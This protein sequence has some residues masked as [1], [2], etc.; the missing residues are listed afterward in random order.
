MSTVSPIQAFR[1]SN[2][3]DDSVMPF[4]VRG[5]GIRGRLVRLGDTVADIV[6]RH[7]YPRSVSMLLAEAVALT[8]MLGSSL[9]FEGKLIL[10]ARG[11]GPV[12]ILVV[13]FATPGL[14]RGYAHFDRGRVMAL[15]REAGADTGSLLGDG[16]LAMTIDQGAH[17]ERY[18]GIV[19]LNGLSLTEASNTYFR[20]SE[21]L[22]S[23]V[24]LAAGPIQ[25]FGTR[26]SESWRAGGILIQH[27][28]DEGEPSPI[29]MS[30]GDAPTGEEM[31]LNE[32][33]RWVRGRLLLATV[34]DHELLDPLL[35]PERLLYRLFHEDGVIAYQPAGIS[36]YCQCSQEKVADLLG[37]FSE[38]ELADM[39]EDGQVEV[40]CEFCSE[41]YTFERSELFRTH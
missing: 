36:R 40:T 1:E 16:H 41:R 19:P 9:K 30:S 34:E 20:Q 37:R 3:H 35:A 11:D 24:R 27:L 10:Q 2:L 39:I 15:E 5:L 23:D 32:D 7:D 26:G 38:A 12:D 31:P 17:M 22:P 8:A 4:E 29:A 18:Q 14:M 6:A 33:D 28:P 25:R 21:Q 13:D